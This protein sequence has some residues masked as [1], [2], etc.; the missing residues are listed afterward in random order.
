MS[1]VLVS[2]LPPRS[3]AHELRCVR[4]D[5]GPGLRVVLEVPRRIDQCVGSAVS[6]ISERAAVQRRAVAWAG[7]ELHAGVVGI[8]GASSALTYVFPPATHKGTCGHLEC[9][10]FPRPERAGENRGQSPGCD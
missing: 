7:C 3:S 1:L 10:H 9:L 5:T 2:N 4:E 8:E 6:T